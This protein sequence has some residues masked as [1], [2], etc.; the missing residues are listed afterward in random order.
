MRWGDQGWGAARAGPRIWSRRLV[1]KG[2]GATS[3]EQNTNLGWEGPGWIHD[4][5]RRGDLEGGARLYQ[6]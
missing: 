2:G 6:F 4:L 5:M 1:P 3:S